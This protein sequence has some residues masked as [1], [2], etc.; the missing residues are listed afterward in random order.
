RHLAAGRARLVR[1]LMTEG[2][3]LSAIAAAGGLLVARWLRD[4][5]ALLVP[6]RGGVLLRLPGQLDARVLALAGATCAVSTLLFA[7]VP[8]LAASRVDLANALRAQSG[9]LVGGRRPPSLP[10]PPT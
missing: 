3:L 9:S 6:P 2:L 1:Q 10:A 5:L 4:A 8:A 7:L